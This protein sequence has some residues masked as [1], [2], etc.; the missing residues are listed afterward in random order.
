MLS[1]HGLTCVRGTRPLFSGLAFTLQPG[2]WAQVRGPNGA[3]KTSLLRLLAGL[4]Q[5]EAGEVRWNGEKVGGEDTYHVWVKYG[6]QNQEADWYFSKKDFL[7]RRVDRLFP[8]REGAPAGGRSLIVTS[9]TPAPKFDKD[10]FKLDL[11][12][13]YTKSDDFA[14]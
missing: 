12:E 1:V 7:P 14:P 6:V 4:A 8:A 5:P 11:P 13:G 2:D 10:P 3:G 9:V